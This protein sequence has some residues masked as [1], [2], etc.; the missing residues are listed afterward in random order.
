MFVVLGVAATTVEGLIRTKASRSVELPGVMDRPGLQVS[1]SVPKGVVIQEM[2]ALQ[3]D[4]VAKNQ[5]L[6]VLDKLAMQ[7][8]LRGFSEELL[9]STVLELCLSGHKKGQKGNLPLEPELLAA[10]SRAERRCRSEISDIEAHL[11]I[12]LEQEEILK[13]RIGLIE[14]EIRR[15]AFEVDRAPLRSKQAIKWAL[16]RNQLEAE[17]IALKKHTENRR[18]EVHEGLED[19]IEQARLDRKRLE[20]EKQALITAIETERILSPIAGTVARQRS[21]PPGWRAAEATDV[22]DI[23][24]PSDH[25]AEVRVALSGIMSELSVGQQL[26]VRFEGLPVTAP[27][28]TAKV[29]LIEN[30]NGHLEARLIVNP[31]DLLRLERQFPQLS[32]A[33]IRAAVQVR[34][35]DD[36]EPVL[37]TLRATFANAVARPAIFDLIQNTRVAQAGTHVQNQPPQAQPP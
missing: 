28:L 13:Q 23:K 37:K 12:A 6:I 18:R 32:G 24:S 3:G 21:L 5:T 4:R 31:A 7:D 11:D 14:T 33:N 10:L 1:V 15:E 27:L 16:A 25:P 26:R 34:V 19:L 17:L 30:I 29:S 20:G 8:E 9:F 36:A 35:F 2:L 22:V